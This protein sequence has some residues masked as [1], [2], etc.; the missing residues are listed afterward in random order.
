MGGDTVPEF[1]PSITLPLGDGHLSRVAYRTDSFDGN[2]LIIHLPKDR[3]ASLV[4]LSAS[5]EVKGA[6][7]NVG[8]LKIVCGKTT[9]A[10]SQVEPRLA[11]EN[12]FTCSVTATIR[13]DAGADAEIRVLSLAPGGAAVEGRYTISRIAAHFGP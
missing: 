10:G 12:E 1:E 9:Y 8:G 5:A 4:I 13:I 3:D 2:G 11:K 7:P 6:V